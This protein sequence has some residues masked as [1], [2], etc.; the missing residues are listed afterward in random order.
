MVM[1]ASS[2]PPAPRLQLHASSKPARRGRAPPA[3]TH[4]HT[5]PHTA[6]HAAP[7]KQT[8]CK[9]SQPYCCC[10]AV[11]CA[12][13]PSPT[14]A[15]HPIRLHHSPLGRYAAAPYTP[16]P[17]AASTSA[18][19]TAPPAHPPRPGRRPPDC[20]RRTGNRQERLGTLPLPHTDPS[21]PHQANTRGM[22]R[23]SPQDK[24]V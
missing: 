5:P 15:C 3:V 21:R 24:L 8:A 4:T 18:P 19:P 10:R 23:W 2:T 13:P 7:S 12:L 11:P 22:T 16:Q 1:P 14:P 20:P 17:G 9:T 6:N